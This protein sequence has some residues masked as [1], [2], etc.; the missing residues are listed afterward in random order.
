MSAISP[1]KGSGQ[2]MWRLENN[3]SNS[4]DTTAMAS[5]VAKPKA[6]GE[7]QLRPLLET[8][9]IHGTPRCYKGSQLLDS[10]T[11]PS[12]SP[13]PP[14]HPPLT[15]TSNPYSYPSPPTHPFAACVTRV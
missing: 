6:N 9:Y 13:T 5:T 10:L 12:R 2:P 3:N 15:P 8:R 11:T 4:N 14:A 1:P 7:T